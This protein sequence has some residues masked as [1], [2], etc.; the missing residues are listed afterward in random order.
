MTTRIGV[1]KISKR[2]F[3]KLGAFSNPALF[4]K[5]DKR[6]RWSHFIDWRHSA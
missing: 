4:R 5:A 1:Q 3:Y 6:G 2:E